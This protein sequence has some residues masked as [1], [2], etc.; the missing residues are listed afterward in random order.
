MS[1]IRFIHADHLRLAASPAGIADAPAWLKQLACDSVRS[2][3][4]NVVEAAVAQDADFLLIAGRI[5]EST[6]DL[7]S[8]ARW[9]DA[10][11]ETLRRRGIRIVAMAENSREAEVLG[12]ICSV[13]V[14]SGECLHVAADVN[15]SWQLTTSADF[16]YAQSDLVISFNSGRAAVG[17]TI[18]T[19]LPSMQPSAERNRNS[20]DG[21]PGLSAGAVQAITPAETWSGGCIVIDADVTSREIK[22][23]FLPCDVL[24]YATEELCLTSPASV[25]SLALEIARASESLRKVDSPTVIIDWRV[26]AE[27]V[28]ELSDV[29][30]LDELSLLLR[31]RGELQSGHFGTW[32]RRVSFSH[33][34]RLKL[35]TQGSEAVDEFVDVAS[36]S[37][38]TYDLDRY[39][40]RSS[41]IRAGK[42]VDA[43]LVAGLQLLGRV[44]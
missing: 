36:E 14:R 7:E 31:L 3:V 9:L 38:I 15:D 28:A 44:A 4:R 11:F 2:A 5:T 39:A 34:S 30:R 40:D 10:Q 25:E 24:R 32:P 41:V 29:L 27:L 17:R 13:V 20:L 37:V 21:Y 22:S 42:G 43:S 16:N 19:A 18:Y 8:V 1:T 33:S 26:S 35:M 12:R 23:Q 6:D